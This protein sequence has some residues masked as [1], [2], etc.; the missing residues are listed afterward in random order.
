MTDTEIN[1]AIADLSG[2]RLYVLRKPIHDPFGYYRDNACGYTGSAAGAWKVTE[3][4]AKKYITGPAYKNEPDKV[5]MEPAAVPNYV[6]DLNAM[7]EAE[8]TLP[9]DR[10]VTHG[11]LLACECGYGTWDEFHF[12][13]GAHATA[14][15]RAKAFLR[16]LG[17]WREA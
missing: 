12:F 2:P 13:D 8:K 14:R 9:R 10:Q 1:Q 11:A 15:Q 4:E 16:T 3:E 6:G 7:H 17:K 5:I